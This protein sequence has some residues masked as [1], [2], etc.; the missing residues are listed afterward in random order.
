MSADVQAQPGCTES[1]NDPAAGRRYL[2]AIV[3]NQ[4]PLAGP[5]VGLAGAAVTLLPHGEIA[6]AISSVVVEHLEATAEQVLCH[7]Q[8]I[9]TLMAGRPTLPVRF[10][11][12]LSS[13]EQVLDSLQGRYST[14]C[15]D[16][17]RLAGQVEIGLRVRWDRARLPQPEPAAVD[18]TLPPAV[19]AG[20]AG[21]GTQYIL[22]R[23]RAGAAQ[24][25]AELQA[26]QIEAWCKAELGP[27]CRAMVTRVLATEN[28][29]VS[30]ACLLPTAGVPALL[31]AAQAMQQD[32]R[33][34][35][36]EGLQF[37]CTGPWPP[38]NFVTPL[39]GN[40]S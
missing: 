1:S 38:Y 8:V 6:A 32:E 22:A 13:P 16:L 4:G 37:V 19:D 21:P 9:E 31:A 30:A 15:S 26:R 12:V 5:I 17:A 35:A 34:P 23:L 25:S 11:T 20:T 24:R 14:L 29:P 28:L 40:A 3:A 2:Y 18:S 7:E 10:G 39:A 36:V 33:A 27:L